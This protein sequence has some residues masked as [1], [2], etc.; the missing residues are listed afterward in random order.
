MSRKGDQSHE[1]LTIGSDRQ[2]QRVS[3]DAIWV[4]TLLIITS[5]TVLL[6]GFLAPITVGAIIGGELYLVAGVTFFGS[7]LVLL[8]LFPVGER[9]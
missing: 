3:D 8:S 7:F 2:R 1:N 6:M 4:L 9:P 5:G